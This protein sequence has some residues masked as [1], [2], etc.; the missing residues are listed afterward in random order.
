MNDPF[1]KVRNYC[2]TTSFT[3]LITIIYV[4]IFIVF[5][6]HDFRDIENAFWTKGIN[7]FILKEINTVI[8][9][10]IYFL[11]FISLGGVLLLLLPFLDKSVQKVYEDW[12]PI[13]SF[14]INVS[15]IILSSYGYKRQIVDEKYNISS[16]P[17]FQAMIIFSVGRASH[18]ILT[19]VLHRFSIKRYEKD[20]ENL[21]QSSNIP[22][23]S[24]SIFQAH[25]D[26]SIGSSVNFQWIYNHSRMF[27]KIELFRTIYYL[28]FPIISLALNL[29][30]MNN[31]NGYAALLL[32]KGIINCNIFII[33]NSI[34]YIINISNF[35][36]GLSL[37]KTSGA[38]QLE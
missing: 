37:F 26:S 36:H 3:Y 33:A 16:S 12:S 35:F 21:R 20:L 29:K 28:I 10:A 1:K 30:S 4:T 14:I 5:V 7:D 22:I 6:I 32:L 2:F 13:I 18:N 25:D 27:A 17:F 9:I 11:Y 23:N 38:I 24:Y 15:A 8:H 31:V 19:Q 34:V